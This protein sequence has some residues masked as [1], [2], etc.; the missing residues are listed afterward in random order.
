MCFSS[1][2]KLLAVFPAVKFMYAC[3]AGE[4]M[5]CFARPGPQAGCIVWE[6]KKNSAKG[7]NERMWVIRYLTRYLLLRV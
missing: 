3:R 5:R 2:E 4:Y 1:F 7:R 6:M